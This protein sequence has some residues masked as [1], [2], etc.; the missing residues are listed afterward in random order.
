MIRCDRVIVERGGRMVVDRISLDVAPGE[1]LAVVGRSG[2]GKSSL[3]A[4]IAGGLPFRGGD[5]VVA[6]HSLRRDGE[7]AR[8]VMGYLP[9]SLPFRPGVR[10][11]EF[12]GL[13]AS[14]AGL[15][16][17]GL[18]SAVG[19]GLDWAGLAGRGD[20]RID[21]LCAGQARRLLIA[22]AMLHA[23]AVLVLD[24][25]LA[26][27]DPEERAAVERLIGDMHIA[28]GTVIAAI[29]DAVVPECFTHLAWMDHGRVLRHDRLVFSS[30]APGRHWRF[31]MRCP[32]AAEAAL[33][34]VAR[35]ASSGSGPAGACEAVDADSVDILLAGPGS[36]AAEVVRA[37]VRAGIG[38]E[39]FAPHP[40]W[41]AQLIA[42]PP[43]PG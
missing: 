13:F 32:G 26:G 37:V 35:L 22:R 29:D 10:A 42:G 18:T 4:A 25:P 40:A 23:P 41:T 14:A 28:G 19:R 31:R 27:L 21:E 24:D 16:G 39:S 8:A 9:G 3:L 17:R 2:A 15:H 11:D 5:V 20:T 12:L 34:A 1:T 30:F 7:A 36:A 6:G 33:R 43:P 38:V